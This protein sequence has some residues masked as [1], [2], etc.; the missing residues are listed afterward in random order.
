MGPFGREPLDSNQ[1]CLQKR[2]ILSP[3]LLLASFLS[4]LSCGSDVYTIPPG[5]D[6]LVSQ[7]GLEPP[8]YCLEGSC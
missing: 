3:Y 4:K 7:E 2:R 8:T 6:I 1:G 5:P